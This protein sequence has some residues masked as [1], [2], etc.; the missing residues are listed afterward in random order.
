[1]FKTTKAKVIFVVIF[2]VI[3]ISIT[4]GLILYKNIDI[5]QYSLEDGNMTAE[6]D[7]QQ[8][9]V[10]GIDLKGTY[11]QND[12]TIQE[13]RATKE[14]VEISY[15]QIY[16]LKDKIIQDNINKELESV[17]LNFY[18]EKIKDLNEVI[19]VSVSMTNT[20]NFAN[21][22]SFKVEYIAKIDDDADGF[23]Q[24]SKGIN[25]NL[26]TGEEIAIGELFTSDA[27]IEDILRKSSYY[28]LIPNNLEDNL[29]GDFVVADYGDIEDDIAIFIDQYKKG[30]INGFYF[31][32]K[33]I[34]IYYGENNIITINMKEYADYIAIYNRYLT[35]ETIFET[36]NVGLKN[37]YTL[38]ERYTV[39]YRYTNYEK[40]SNYFIDINI[41]N[42]DGEENELSQKLLQDKIK[43][44]EAEIEKTKAI[45]N[46]DSSKFYIL[47]YYIH[48][49]TSDIYTTEDHS[50]KETLTTCWEIG[51]SY[52]ITVHDFEE[53]IEPIIVK[54]NRED[55]SGDL[56]IY[57]YDFNEV[58][59]IE[60]QQTTEYYNPETEEKVVI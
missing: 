52:E 29:S 41:D 16:G 60:P 43:E 28:S 25:Y 21:A 33:Y 32:P 24:D 6:D 27:P 15:F 18:R 9:D 50:T 54:Y 38:S 2:C 31:S 7:V 37:L 45:A 11:N 12:L 14:N 23:Y 19:N 36:N 10:A 13:K 57:L 47:N 5:D 51:N 59:K 53:S 42:V 30:K 3:C 48:I 1:M 55:P 22:I 56:P 44:I 8:K 39:D 17:A 46:R 20:G 34:Y 4:L 58:L 26:T 35:Y 40:G 49:Y